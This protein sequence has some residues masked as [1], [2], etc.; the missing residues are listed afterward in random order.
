[1][2]VAPDTEKPGKPELTDDEVEK[3]DTLPADDEIARYAKDAQRRIK[4]LHIANQEWRRRVVQ[5]SKD[6]ATATSLAEQLY[7]ENQQLKAARERSDMALIDQALQRTEAQLAQAQQRAELAYAA[8]DTKAITAAN[9]ELARCVTEADRL[10]L[11][12]PP[13]G[14]ENEPGSPA[15]QSEAP[16]QQAPPMTDGTKAWLAKNTWFNKPGEAKMTSFAMG[17][18]KDLEEQGITE[19]SNPNA[20]WG[21]IDKALRETFPQRFAET[22]AER[23]AN[24]IGTARTNGAPEPPAK[25]NPRHVTLTESEVRIARSLG[26]S[27]EQYAAQKLKDEAAKERGQ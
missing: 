26:I 8:N 25:R 4:S 5:H 2:E 24:V 3:L 1:V 6:V 22:R 14:K 20:Y 12:K 21:A 7:R 10:R 23:P 11:L 17:V 27:N 19:A 18:H 15:P 13:P 9:I 16:P